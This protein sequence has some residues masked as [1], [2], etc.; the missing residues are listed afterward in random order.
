MSVTTTLYFIREHS[1]SNK[2]VKVM[3]G[4]RNIAGGNRIED[5]SVNR[6]DARAIIQRGM[7]ISISDSD[8]D[9]F[10]R[11]NITLEVLQYATA[12]EK[13]YFLKCLMDGYTGSDDE[14]AMLR[15]LKSVNSSEEMEQVMTQAGGRQAVLDELGDKAEDFMQYLQGRG[16]MGAREIINLAGSYEVSDTAGDDFVRRYITP[17]VLQYATA[18]EKAHFLRCLMDGYTGSDDEDAMLRI[19]T[20]TTD[21]TQI[22]TILNSV[23]RTEVIDELEDRGRDFIN[24]LRGLGREGYRAIADIALSY[25][26]EDSNS[27]DF[28]RNY[29]DV[30]VLSTVNGVEKSRM[31]RMLLDGPTLKG[32]EEAIVRILESSSR[33]P[34]QLHEIIHGAGVQWLLN[35]V[36]RNDLHQVVQRYVFNDEMR[37]RPPLNQLP[38]TATDEQINARLDQLERELQ[39]RIAR[40]QQMADGLEEAED[41]Q[42]YQELA[43]TAR[44]DLQ[45]LQTN[46]A[47]ATNSA[48][49]LRLFNR[50]NF[51]THIEFGYNVNLTHTN[52]ATWTTAEL[53]DI[54]DALEQLPAAHTVMNEALYEIRRDRVYRNPDGTE[55]WNVGGVNHQGLI[56][57][58]N[59]GA[60]GVYRHTALGVNPITEVLV[61]EIGHHMD[62]ENP[63]WNDFLA[64]SG[65][66]QLDADTIGDDTCTIDGR[67]Y[68]DGD[69]I[70]LDGANYIIQIEYGEVWAYQQG[71]AFSIGNYNRVHPVED[72]AEAYTEFVVAPRELRTRAPDKYQFMVDFFGYDPLRR[73][74]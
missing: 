25:D 51:E 65:W 57:I 27:D 68:N 59:T 64:L 17:E 37:Q 50:L 66:R 53:S 23:G 33:S 18:E 10:V 52:T 44:R 31:L 36:D 20:S 47:N 13:A 62:D 34:E 6:E 28:V 72:F 4:V 7:N 2:E 56:E 74:P 30:Q 48:E 45:D 41:E 8:S 73:I 38:A 1:I 58:F 43:D 39:Q 32:D 60:A 63:R 16:E 14:M 29:I 26:I 21:V 55:D 54:E 71:A 12:E 3:E 9:D 67:T 35:D 22:N 69:V 19:L 24:H 15:I 46:R 40:Y 61:H 70:R 11:E 42:F 5:N 49:R